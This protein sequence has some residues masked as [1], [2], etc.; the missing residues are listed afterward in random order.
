MTSE[1]T[2]A[3]LPM[4]QQTMSIYSGTSI[5]YIKATIKSLNGNKRPTHLWRVGVR[6]WAK[7]VGLDRSL[8][9]GEK[10]M[11]SRGDVMTRPA[12]WR[13]GG[14]EGVIIILIVRSLCPGRKYS[15]MK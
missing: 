4:E 9:L 15:N 13:T 14:L 5:S 12:G 2:K 3:L 8:S 10:M 1:F 6:A 11:S 7:S